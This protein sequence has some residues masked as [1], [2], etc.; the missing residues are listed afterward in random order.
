VVEQERI[1]QEL[2]GK[3]RNAQQR[4]YLDAVSP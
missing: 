4:D 3:E 1:A 2:G